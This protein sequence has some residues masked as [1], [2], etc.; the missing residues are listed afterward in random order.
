[1]SRFFEKNFHMVII[2]VIV[3]MRKK[4]IL[5]SS[6]KF[7]DIFIFPVVFNPNTKPVHL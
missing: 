5:I 2:I 3:K 4:I 1:M 7:C 6:R